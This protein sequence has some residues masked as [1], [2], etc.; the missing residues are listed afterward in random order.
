MDER[1]EEL[2]ADQRVEAT[3]V[4]TAVQLGITSVDLMVDLTVWR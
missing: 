3:V 2:M 4:S 1:L